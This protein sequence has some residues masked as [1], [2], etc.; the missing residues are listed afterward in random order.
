MKQTMNPDAYGLDK[1]TEC[2]IC[3]KMGWRL[4][5][6]FISHFERR[7]KEAVDIWGVPYMSWEWVVAKECQA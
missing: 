1:R 5:K 3:H 6:G 2:P 7:P 4:R